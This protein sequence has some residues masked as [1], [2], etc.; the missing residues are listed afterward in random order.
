LTTSVHN[1]K[2]KSSKTARDKNFL[3]P[4]KKIY[5]K[6]TINIL[7]SE[8]LNSLSPKIRKRE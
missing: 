6:P 4:L 3:S 5:E 7:N 1:L 2:I 8:K